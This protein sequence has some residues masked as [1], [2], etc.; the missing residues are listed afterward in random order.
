[1]EIK[2]RDREAEGF[3]PSFKRALTILEISK[4]ERT[5]QA[6]H[7]KLKGARAR[8]LRAVEGKYKTRINN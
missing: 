4:P 3:Y 5:C 8:E 6:I 1:M 7:Y 2:S